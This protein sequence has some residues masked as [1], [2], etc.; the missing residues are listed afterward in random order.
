M[1]EVFAPARIC[2]FG[3]HQ[4]YLGLPV[5]ACA[6][7]K[8]IKLIAKKNNEVFFNIS[9]PDIGENR[10]IEISKI[11][12]TVTEQDFFLKTLEV[13]REYKCIPTIGYDIII[14]GDIPVNAGLSSSSAIIVVWITFLLKAYG[15]HLEI[16]TSFIASL[17]Y[18]I[19]VLEF[20]NPGGLM[21]Q[22]SISIGNTLFIDTVS[23][24]FQ[25]LNKPNMSLIIGE[26]GVPKKTLTILK[27]LKDYAIEVINIVQ[28]INPNFKIETSTTDDFEKYKD[29]LAKNLQPVFQAAINNYHITM[30]A[31]NELGKREVDIKKIGKL[32]NDHHKELKKNLRITVPII[33]S[34]IN[35]AIENGALGAK[36]VGSGGGG[37]IVAICTPEK[38]NEIIQGIINSGAKSAYKVEISKGVL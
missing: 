36:I 12:S 4:D 25:E 9:L 2:L 1:I 17:A 31:Y 10:S 29:L 37:C 23:G 3:D 6:I 24:N 21:D 15:K 14:S 33:D 16:S 11:V 34:M 28:S 20:K 19:E 30:A 18:R 5:I 32:I 8:H 27:N 26:S 35:G 7:N 38:E 13:L 22:Y